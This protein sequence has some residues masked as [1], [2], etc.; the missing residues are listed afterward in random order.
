MDDNRPPTS[1]TIADLRAQARRLLA[2]SKLA[3]H[4]S[5]M[6]RLARRAFELAK[7]AEELERQAK[8]A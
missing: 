2:E 7:E 3:V 5:D 1:Q 4:P 8:N 6:A